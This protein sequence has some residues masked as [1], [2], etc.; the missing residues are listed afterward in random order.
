MPH[1]LFGVCTTCTC[2]ISYPKP[3]PNGDAVGH[4]FFGVC[5]TCQ[6]PLGYQESSL[7]KCYRSKS[8]GTFTTE[9]Y[10]VGHQAGL[11]K[12]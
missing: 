5:T 6:C 3:S 2:P 8:G 12:D 11:R 10:Q 7:R 1:T 9:Y 4:R